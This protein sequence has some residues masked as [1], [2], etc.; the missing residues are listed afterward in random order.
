MSLPTGSSSE[1]EGRMKVWFLLCAWRC[2]VKAFTSW[3]INVF[4]TYC[5]FDEKKK[6]STTDCR[7]FVCVVDEVQNMI[8]CKQMKIMN[9]ILSGSSVCYKCSIF[10]IDFEEN[11]AVLLNSMAQF[12]Y[13]S[14]KTFVGSFAFISKE[15]CNLQTNVTFKIL[16]TRGRDIGPPGREAHPHQTTAWGWNQFETGSSRKHR[17]T[18]TSPESSEE[19]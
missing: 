16:R 6:F 11:S 19:P 14:G 15:V 5:I 4:W 7:Y 18:Y 10:Y 1:S 12:L 3:L 13:L 2:E 17:A 9:P 8:T